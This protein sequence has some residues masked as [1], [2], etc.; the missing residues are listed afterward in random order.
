MKVS[1]YFKLL[2]DEISHMMKNDP[3]LSL[4][5]VTKGY[6]IKYVMVQLKGRCNP[7][8]VDEDI[9]RVYNSMI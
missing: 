4:N 3:G 6:L 8:Q 5:S 2:E 7:K 1:E 9:C